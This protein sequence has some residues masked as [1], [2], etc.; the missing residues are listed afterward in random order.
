MN[1]FRVYGFTLETDFPFQTPLIPAEASPDLTFV[2]SPVPPPVGPWR[3]HP[4]V[5]ESRYLTE[6]GEPQMRLYRMDDLHVFRQTDVA[7]YYMWPGRVVCHQ[8]D[9]T[10]TDVVELLFLSLLSGYWLESRGSVVLHASAVS[11]RDGAVVF[12]ATNRGGKTSLSTSLLQAGHTLLTDDLLAVSMTGTEAIGH[13]GFPQMRMWP[14]VADHFLGGHAHLPPVLPETGKLR[15]RVE[16]EKLGAFCA[17]DRP[18]TRLYLPEREDDPEA[19]IRAELVPPQ[20]AL[21]E[22]VRESFLTTVLEKTGLHR[23]RFGRLT[24]L[25]NHV[26]MKRLI[27]PAGLDRLPSVRDAILEDLEAAW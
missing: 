14:D 24:S 23:K 12:L 3:D 7:D 1:R 21:I 15:V 19:L 5:F 25:V 13:P 27:Y 18:L 17:D 4:A 8:H 20:Q 10:A 11:V 9:P 16:E 26:P 2:R 6:A 22:L